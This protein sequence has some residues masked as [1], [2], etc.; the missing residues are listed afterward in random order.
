MSEN[1]KNVNEEAASIS[2]EELTEQRQIRRQKLKDLQEA[3]RNPF[4]QETWDVNAYSG[5]IKADFDSM[6]QKTV[7]IA[8]RMMAKRVMG[9]ASFIDI[10]D[11]RVEFSVISR[12][13]FWGRK[14]TNGLRRVI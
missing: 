5:D 9:K 6:D 7:S 11:K 1:I 4:L 10:Q 13:M 12:E 2:E 8:G 3:G 14:N